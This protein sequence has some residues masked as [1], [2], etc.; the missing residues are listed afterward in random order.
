MSFGFYP[1]GWGV[2]KAFPEASSVLC[3]HQAA[4]HVGQYVDLTA[5]KF[6]YS[7]SIL[8]HGLAINALAHLIQSC[9]LAKKGMLSHDVMAFGDPN[10][11]CNTLR[12]LHTC[13]LSQS[14]TLLLWLKQTF[15]KSGKGQEEEWEAGSQ[16]ED[17]RTSKHQAYCRQCASTHYIPLW[18]MTPWLCLGLMEDN[19]LTVVATIVLVLLSQQVLQCLHSS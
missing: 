8:C 6:L 4:W 13:R 5:D 2:I 18:K 11:R 3:G 10:L 17:V 7:S 15:L 9:W 16:L 12:V 19:S 14:R 1:G